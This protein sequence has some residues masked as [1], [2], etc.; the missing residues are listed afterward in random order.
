[1]RLYTPEES[2]TPGSRRRAADTRQ[3]RSLLRTGP[4][5]EGSTRVIPPF[6]ALWPSEGAGKV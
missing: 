3:T 2:D 4:V 5:S 6:A 1:M